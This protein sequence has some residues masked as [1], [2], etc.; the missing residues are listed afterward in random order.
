MYIDWEYYKIFY[1]VARCGNITRAARILGSNQP[2]ITHAINRL[3]GQLNCVLFVRSNRGVTMTP[4]GELLYAR[5]ASAAAQIQEA[6]EEMSASASLAHGSVSISATETALAITLSDKLREFRS[7]YP[8]IRLRI[9]N[10]STPQAVQ[11]VRSGEVDFAIVTTPVETE[12]PIKCVE[13]ARF[14]EILIAGKSFSAL[15]KKKL[16]LA[17]LADHPLICL[18][19]GSMTRAFYNQLFAEHGATLQPDTEAAT[20]DQILT[21]VR[22]ELGLAFLPEPMA[23]TAVARREVVRLHLAEPIP[24]RA[25]CLLY[26]RHRPLNTAS[27]EF[28]RMLTEEKAASP[29]KSAQIL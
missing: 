23:R 1:H 18:G 24:R 26:D 15:A 28:Q 11:A 4:E 21:L 25:I 14:D 20:T 7:A 6:E 8:G 17:E 27:R 22:S 3:E 16:T 19:T 12:L 2:N 5:I 9:T 13:L 10:H 29:I